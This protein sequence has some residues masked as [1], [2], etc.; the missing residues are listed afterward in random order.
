MRILLTMTMHE[1][2]SNFLVLHGKIVL[3]ALTIII[4]R[5]S[6]RR[7]PFVTDVAGFTGSG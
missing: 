4:S 5:W 6:L 1:I 3:K 7:E 2:S